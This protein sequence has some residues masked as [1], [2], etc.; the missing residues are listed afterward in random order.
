[1]IVMPRTVAKMTSEDHSSSLGI[2][3]FERPHAISY[4]SPTVTVSACTVYDLSAENSSASFNA[5]DVDGS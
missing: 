1:M 4:Q 2:T 5:V 3:S